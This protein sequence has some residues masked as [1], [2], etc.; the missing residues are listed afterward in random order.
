MFCT[1]FAA[2]LTSQMIDSSVLLH[3]MCCHLRAATQAAAA[4][5]ELRPQRHS[6]P[7]LLWTTFWKSLF[8]LEVCPNISLFCPYFF[9]DRTLY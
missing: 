6:N 2:I 1:D 8:V 9:W 3:R 7:K 5:L 4:A